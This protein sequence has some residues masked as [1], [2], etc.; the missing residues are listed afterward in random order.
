[1]LTLRRQP[2]NEKI[3]CHRAVFIEDTGKIARL[4]D[5]QRLCALRV[6][7]CAS[8]REDDKSITSKTATGQVTRKNDL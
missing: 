1:M 4:Q 5:I 6:H 2:K 7:H 8:A 3:A